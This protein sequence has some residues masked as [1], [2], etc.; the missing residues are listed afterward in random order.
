[1]KGK[2]WEFELQGG[3]LGGWNYQLG[4]IIKGMRVSIEAALLEEWE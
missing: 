3:Q 4:R 1:M 2:S